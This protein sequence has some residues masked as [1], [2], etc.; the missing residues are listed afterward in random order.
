MR[1]EVVEPTIPESAKK[2]M[3]RIGYAMIFIGVISYSSFV[4]LLLFS[5]EFVEEF[6]YF[7]IL[8]SL[9]FGLLLFFTGVSLL[10]YRKW[11]VTVAYWCSLTLVIILTVL[12]LYIFFTSAGGLLIFD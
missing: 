9:P 3:R 4:L 5:E 6:T 7:D 8:I 12:N 10:L 2:T 11:S 1:K